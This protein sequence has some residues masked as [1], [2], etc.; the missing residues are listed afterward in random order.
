M[1]ITK[2]IVTLLLVVLFPILF[3]YNNVLAFPGKLLMFNYISLII[4]RSGSNYLYVYMFVHISF[5][6]QIY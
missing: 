4:L 1:D 3:Y 6:Y 2:N 5:Y